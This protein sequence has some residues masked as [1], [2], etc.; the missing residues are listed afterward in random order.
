MLG[1]DTAPDIIEQLR[2]LGSLGLQAHTQIVLC[3]G[4][5]DGAEL[6]RSIRDLAALYPTV[7]TMSV[8]PVGASP[9]LE[10]WSLNARRHRTRPPQPRLRADNRHQVRAL[11]REIRAARENPSSNAATNIMSPPIRPSPQPRRTMAIPSTRTAS[12]WSATCSRIGSRPAHACAKP[13]DVF[14]GRHIVIATAASP[15][16]CCHPSHAN[17]NRSPAPASSPAVDKHRLRRT[18]ERRRSPLR[19][20]LHRR[21]RSV[22][23]RLLHPSPSEPR[24]LRRK[25]PRQHERRRSESALGAP[26]TFAARWSDVVRILEKGPRRP[27]RNAAPNGAFWSEPHLLHTGAAAPR[28]TATAVRGNKLERDSCPGGWQCPT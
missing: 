5:N 19:E 12:V 14:A 16:A 15:P 26:L 10:D 7:Q 1:N 21:T 27:S 20:G 22:P 25:V 11:Q 8:V 24:L 17:S 6:D 28:D 18:C 3:P 9:K 2:R 4:V 13:A 23:P